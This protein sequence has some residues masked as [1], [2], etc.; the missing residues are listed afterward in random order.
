MK[1]ISGLESGRDSNGNRWE[2]YEENGR[3]RWKK[4]GDKGEVVQESN[5][6]YGSMEM[7]EINAKAHGMDG[8]F[9]RLM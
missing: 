6:D 1:E 7:C 8:N 2:L 9:F 3:W 5:K 4:F